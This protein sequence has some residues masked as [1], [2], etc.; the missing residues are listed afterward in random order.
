MV[1]G[2]VAFIKYVSGVIGKAQTR[3]EYRQN[4]KYDGIGYLEFSG[5][6]PAGDQ[7]SQCRKNKHMRKLHVR[8]K[9]KSGTQNTDN[10][11]HRGK[12]EY[13]A[14]NLSFLVLLHR[15]F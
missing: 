10:T 1:I 8:N 6:Q 9:Q 13:G 11:A 14:C 15:Q 3:Y 4:H 12:G 2:A 5:Y 7:H